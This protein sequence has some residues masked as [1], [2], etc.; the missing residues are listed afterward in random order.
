V[1]QHAAI[2]DAILA[3][4]A[5]GARRAVARHIG[6]VRAWI[7]KFNLSGISIDDAKTMDDQATSA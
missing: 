1:V 3:K 2:A 7:Q 4:D 5:R 6:S